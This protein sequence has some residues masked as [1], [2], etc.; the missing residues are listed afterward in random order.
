M[1]PMQPQIWPQNKLVGSLDSSNRGIY[2]LSPE[3]KGTV[4]KQI[5]LLKPCDQGACAGNRVG[6]LES[7]ERSI[8]AL[9]PK[10]RGTV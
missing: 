6:S 10:D 5:E 2:L 3:D 1:S 9:R 4:F 7:S 8:Y